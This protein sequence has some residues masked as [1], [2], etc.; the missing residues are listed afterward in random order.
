MSVTDQKLADELRRLAGHS[1][2]VD[3]ED[4]LRELA[5]AITDP[6]EAERWCEIDL[7]AAFSPGDT[8]LPDHGPATSRRTPRR[9]LPLISSVLV[10][11]PIGITWFG[12]MKA[13][14]AYGEVLAA[15]GPDAARRPFLEMWQQGFDGRL[16]DFLKFD[17]VA[18]YTLGAIGF[19]ILV[20]IIEIVTRNSAEDKSDHELAVLRIRLRKALT[21]AS[22]V[23][24]QVRLSS[25]T[26]F[27]AELTK[28]VADINTVGTTVRKAQTELVEA[29]NLTLERTRK[30]TEALAA[31]VVDVQGA[32]ETLGKHLANINTAQGD[33]TA[34]VE[35]AAAAI[36]VAGSTTGQ[37]VAGVGDQL[38]TVIS[39]TILDMRR[40]F[41]DEL[42]QS[43]QSVQ[44]T[45]SSLGSHVGELVDATASMRHTFND[46]LSQSMKSIQGTVSGLDSHV[47][48]LVTATA[49]I[50]YAVD[51]A[52]DSIDSV[53]SSTEKAVGLIGGQVTD[54]IT[55]T[56][57]EFRRTFGDTGTEIREA[58][59]DWSSTAGA[60]ASRI[61]LVSDTAGR[62][63]ALLE[64]TRG[65]LD[66]LPTAIANVLADLPTRMKE[67]TDGEFA[68]LKRVIIGLQSAVDRAA[69][70]LGAS[71]RGDIPDGIQRTPQ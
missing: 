3:R 60:H 57:A 15:G 12:L 9:L 17:N 65:T 6:H 7:F 38:S 70:V 35:Q 34:A 5:N 28:T 33:M 24:G 46:E 14:D 68:D 13:T 58:L 54:S 26:R 64:Q 45:V 56:A 25:P 59:G 2:L 63:A 52:A 53:G 31:G 20:T 44:T 21:Q 4:Q 32:V 61:E 27:G 42:A 48:E 39:Q 10:F 18:L 19:L 36:D 22:L 66:Q 11:M 55:I 62:T 23:L 37:A 69:D 50:G 29:L 41:V 47:G 67:L 49:S 1:H 8:I 71:G 30:A 43:T 16:A 51:R 40:A